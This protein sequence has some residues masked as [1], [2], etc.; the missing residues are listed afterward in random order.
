MLALTEKNAVGETFNIASGKATTI[1]MIVQVLQRLTG[2]ENLKPVYEE[3]RESDIRHSYADIEK[4]KR[5]LGYEPKFSLEKGLKELV[6]HM[7]RLV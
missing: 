5:F 6:Q 1:N 2:K 4:A 3:P 7:V